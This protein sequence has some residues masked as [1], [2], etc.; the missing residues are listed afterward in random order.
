MH[1]ELAFV[2]LFLDVVTCA[3][4]FSR[5]FFSYYCCFDFINIIS[6]IPS[7]IKMDFLRVGDPK[8][9]LFPDLVFLYTFCV[10][11]FKLL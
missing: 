8:Y 7:F 2:L 6:L 5:H 9:L 4:N 10:G 3:K 1:R 11:N